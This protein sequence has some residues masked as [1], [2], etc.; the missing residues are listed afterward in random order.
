MRSRSHAA[1]RFGRALAAMEEAITEILLYVGIKNPASIQIA[2]GVAAGTAIVLVPA[3]VISGFFLAL[4]WDSRP[5]W[6][7]P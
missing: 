6:Y 1:R 4:L 3:L 5:P 7:K 2:I